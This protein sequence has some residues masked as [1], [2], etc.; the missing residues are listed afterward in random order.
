MRT[1]TYELKNIIKKKSSFFYFKIFFKHQQKKQEQQ[2]KHLRYQQQQQRHRQKMKLQ[3]I[4]KKK[5]FLIYQI[6]ICEMPNYLIVDVIIVNFKIKI[7]KYI[8]FKINTF[9]ISINFSCDFQA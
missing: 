1:F 9:K 8:Q 6:K 7:H 2:Q 3:K 4:I 5:H